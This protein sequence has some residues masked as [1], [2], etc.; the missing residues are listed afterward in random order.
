MLSLD[1][2]YRF[3]S[4]ERGGVGTWEF[5]P[6]GAPDHHTPIGTTLFLWTPRNM[7]LWPRVWKYRQKYQKV[8]KWFKQSPNVFSKCLQMYENSPPLEPFPRSPKG[9]GAIATGDGLVTTTI[10]FQRSST[11]GFWMKILDFGRQ[12]LRVCVC[13]CVYFCTPFTF[14]LNLRQTQHCPCGKTKQR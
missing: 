1:Q 9:P 3:P 7:F 14:F 11:S 12:I 4:S 2:C 8:W 13:V 10:I 6:R 5:P